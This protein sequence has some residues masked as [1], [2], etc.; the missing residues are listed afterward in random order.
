M[1]LISVIVPVYNNSRAELECCMN[2]I[3]QQTFDDYEV[4]VLDDGSDS[5]CQQYIDELTDDMDNC[6]V[7][8]KDNE[9]VSATRNLGIRYA[10]GEYVTFVDADDILPGY[11]MYEASKALQQTELDII[12]GFVRQV[13]SGDELILLQ[14]E[15]AH[16]SHKSISVEILSELEH[17]RLYCHMFDLHGKEFKKGDLYINRGPVARIVKKSIAEKCEFDISLSLGE[18]AVWNLMLLQTTKKVGIVKSLWYVYFSKEGTAST[19]YKKDF[20]QNCTIML[21]RLWEL[22]YD[23]S[24]KTACLRKILEMTTFIPAY[25]YQTVFFKDRSILSAVRDFNQLLLNYPWNMV[26]HFSNIKNAGWK[27]ILKFLLIKTNL[28]IPACLLFKHK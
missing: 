12:Y 24:S 20:K 19:N 7:F 10:E 15:L 5:D 22:A 2:S 25:Y 23:D 17:K 16:R 28:M 18:D 13:F 27:A 4:L 6:R 21:E 1:P 9:G 26:L 8:H 14:K 3:K 11:F